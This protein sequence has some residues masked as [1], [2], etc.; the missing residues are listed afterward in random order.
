[1][2]SWVNDVR[3]GL[4]LFVKARGFTT[5]AVLSL[6]IGIGVNTATFSV[7]NALLL[8]PLPYPNADRLAILWQR[9]PGLNVAQDW[10]SIGQYL[11]IA[12]ENTVFEAMA[13]AI[14]A[15][16]N[17]TGGARP[18]RLDG[19]R[20]TASFFP[21]FGAR[22]VRGRLLTADDNVPGK[23]LVVVL[24]HGFWQRR[25]AGDTAVVGQTLSLNGNPVTIVGV[26]TPEFTFS[27][28]VM[29]AVNA[30][31]G[32]DVVLPIPMAPSARSNRG[33][34]D[35]NV[36]ARVK[37]GVSLER[38]QLEMAGIAA[39][40]KQQYP[41]NYPP[42]GGLTISIVPLID[43]V[44]G[45]VRLVLYVLLAAVSLVLLIACGNVANL[46]LA[47]AAVREKEIA[48]RSALGAA[49]SRIVRQ[50]LTENLMLAVVSGI[51]GLALAAAGVQAIRLFGPANVPRMDEV[52][53]DGRVLAYTGLISVLTAAL[54][55]IVP[56]LRAAGI[57]VHSVLSEAGRGLS[58]SNSLGFGHGRLRKALITIEVALCVVLLTGAG[59]LVR[60]F[61]RVSAANPGFDPRNALSFRLSLPGT[62]YKTPEMVSGFYDQLSR[63]LR[64]LPGVQLVGMNYQ[65]PLSSVALA[66]EPIGVEGYVPKAP[67]EDL[68]ISSTAYISPDYL[69][70]MRIPLMR[71]RRF[72]AQGNKQ[73]PEVAIVNE[74][75]AARFWPGSDAI[76]KRL[77]QGPNGPWRTIVGVVADTKE[78]ATAAEPPITVYF[79]V[80]QYTIGSRFVVV[81]SAP[82]LDAATLLPDVTRVLRDLDPEL[83][84]YDVATMDARLRDSLARRRLSTLVLGIF[85]AFATL[86]ASIG[87]YALI[88]YWVDQRR[89]E[90]GIRMALGADRSRIL[91][92]VGREFTVMIASGLVIGLA[93]SFA[94]TRLMNALLFHVS[95]TDIATFASVPILVAIVGLCASYLPASR[96]S[97][98]DPALALRFE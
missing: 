72:T 33:G 84:A 85:A 92:L 37:R 35:F 71:G 88:A 78:Y 47:R 91:L 42:N 96:A 30:I 32:T 28:E 43:Q 9:S 24:T 80:E 54:F 26:L 16:F 94:I 44:V 74:A 23:H 98:T 79:P 77:R 53:I 29:P 86:L 59:L 31:R 83:P 11:D 82:S 66:W 52:R 38:A 51:A 8:R 48:I 87:T 7:A 65:L 75:L 45:D 58:G 14:G 41:A 39:H 62:R 95:A 17:L 4:R 3:L 60:S 73:A 10:M 20:V 63:R 40:M 19:V 67:G 34:E 56:A 18:E 70:A 50:L 81:R 61:V 13:A 15:S 64:A 5:A 68:I 76:G 1:M 27:R 89:R 55:G 97:R 12:A 46:Q 57:Q 49:R 93:V 2:E 36:F 22:P 21:L 25:F 90:I 6:A 69:D